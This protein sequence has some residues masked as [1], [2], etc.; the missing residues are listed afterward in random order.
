[1]PSAGAAPTPLHRQVYDSIRVAILSGRLRSGDRLPA[2]RVLA[3]QLALSRSTVAE[4]Y[5]QLRSE[6]YILGRLG[7]GTF[8]AP[9]LPQDALPLPRDRPRARP[10]PTP[11]FG[12]KVDSRAPKAA[13]RPQGGVG[14]G[15]P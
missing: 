4:A 8:V 15:H 9:D 5:E 1:M 7:S 6:G 12:P 14:R 10:R 11:T 2:T 3:E 13:V